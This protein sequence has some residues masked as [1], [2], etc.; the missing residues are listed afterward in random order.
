M[1]EQGSAEQKLHTDV[2]SFRDILGGKYTAYIARKW[3]GR[4]ES[5]RVQKRMGRGGG[6]E[7]TLAGGY[8]A[9]AVG[10]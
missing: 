9:E 3:R 1:R 6:K 10:R 8:A 5:P 7:K 4:A 2:R